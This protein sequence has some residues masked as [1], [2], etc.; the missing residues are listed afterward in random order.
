[1]LAFLVAL[2]TASLLGWTVDSRDGGDW[3]PSDGGRRVPRRPVSGG[4]GG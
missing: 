2:G 3:A 4:G 1:M